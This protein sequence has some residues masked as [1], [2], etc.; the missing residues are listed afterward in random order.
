MRRGP[1]PALAV[2]VLPAGATPPP[3][4]ALLRAGG[5]TV[6][7][8]RDDAATGLGNSERGRIANACGALAF[9]SVHLNSFPE[10]EPNYVR[11][12]WGI[13]GK[14]LAFAETIHA[15]LAAQL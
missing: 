9:V 15:A 14:D 2:R 10:P 13:A 6:A 1:R 7:L 3:G 4:L 12:F 8:T 11:T 5:Y